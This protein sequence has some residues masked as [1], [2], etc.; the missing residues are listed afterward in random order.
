MVDSDSEFEYDL[1]YEPEEVEVG[2]ET[3]LRVWTVVPP[4]IEYISSLHAQ[5]QEIS[6]RQVWTGS[7]ALAQFVTKS[8][9]NRLNNSAVELNL[10]HLLSVKKKYVT[11]CWFYICIVSHGTL[12]THN[13]GSPI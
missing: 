7:L 5:R 2:D 3:V 9:Q 10:D 6:G 8:H 13:W 12:T 11:S 4:P 1:E